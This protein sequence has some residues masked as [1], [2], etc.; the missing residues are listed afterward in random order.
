MIIL[1]VTDLAKD[2]RSVKDSQIR[3]RQYAVNMRNYEDNLREDNERVK[4]ELIRKSALNA[5]LGVLKAIL[6]KASEICLLYM[7]KT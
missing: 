4:N 2:S 7:I 1:A 3:Q 6:I 5:E